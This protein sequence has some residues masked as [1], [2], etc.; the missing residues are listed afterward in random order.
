M[1]VSSEQIDEFSLGTWSWWK[2]SVPDTGRKHWCQPN[3]AVGSRLII[4]H[5]IILQWVTVSSEQIDEFSLG[6]WSWWKRSV[7]DTGRKHWC[8][9]NGA[10]GSRLII[11]HL[12]I[13]QWVTVSSE[14][15]DEFSLGTW[16]WWK[17]S[18]P[19]TGRKHWCQPNGA[20]GS[21]LMII[22]LIILQWV[23]VSAEQIDAFSLGTWRWWRRSVPDAGRKHWYQH[24]GAVR[25][26]LMF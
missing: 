17:R 26:R 10:V 14:Q 11:I 23:T 25:S 22:H 20:V 4:I 21:R 1:T 18:V 3:G 8:Q 7:P 19:D 5:L 15:I 24:N 6:T 12:I 16:S 13:L 9:P 2:R